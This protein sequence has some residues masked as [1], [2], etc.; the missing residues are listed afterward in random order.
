MSDAE[1][2]RPSLLSRVRTTSDHAAWTEFESR[3]GG[4]IARYCRRRGLQPSDVEDVSQ[5]VMMRLARALRTFEYD[6]LR[7]RFRDF[8]GRVVRNVIIDH[9][10]RPGR[11]AT[12]VD[13]S[14]M[15]VVSARDESETDAVWEQEW[16]DHHYRLAMKKIAA[17]FEPR[18]VEIFERIVAG[19]RID[20]I[21]AAC[22]T[23]A[24]AVHKIKQRIRDRMKELIAAQIREED[25]PDG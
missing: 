12:A 15:A 13:S 6:P 11:A 10:S 18:S 17:T 25:F 4:L 8:V 7:G 1:A 16:I 5:L 21:A 2:T 9:F 19:E 20:D 22:G 24:Q 3:Y 23:T 14:V